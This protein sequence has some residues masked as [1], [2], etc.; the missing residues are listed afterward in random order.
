MLGL[1]I[2]KG[3]YSTAVKGVGEKTSLMSRKRARIE[4]PTYERGTG[5]GAWQRRKR[6]EGVKLG[7]TQR[8]GTHIGA[9]KGDSQLKPGL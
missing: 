5:G 6:K 1:S 9:K 7:Y 4:A 2:W 3:G 8:K